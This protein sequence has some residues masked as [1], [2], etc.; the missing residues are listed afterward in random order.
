MVVGG[1]CRTDP[2]DGFQNPVVVAG[3]SPEKFPATFPA[4]KIC[5]LFRICWLFRISLGR[6]VMERRATWIRSRPR[7]RL[8]KDMRPRLH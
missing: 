4:K 5:R 1:A 6:M 2:R 7:K 3:C 8:A